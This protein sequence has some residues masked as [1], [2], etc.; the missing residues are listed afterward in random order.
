M[1]VG[2][3]PSLGVTA[4]PVIAKK[5][6]ERHGLPPKPTFSALQVVWWWRIHA[7]APDF[8]SML[9]VALGNECHRRD[10]EHELHGGELDI[11][12]VQAYCAFHTAGGLGGEAY[13]DA[14]ELGYLEK[15][16]L[17]QFSAGLMDSI[18]APIADDAEENY[19]RDMT[20]LRYLVPLSP[21]QVADN[22]RAELAYWAS[23][24]EAKSDQMERAKADS[25]ASTDEIKVDQ[26]GSDEGFAR[27]FGLE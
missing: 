5:M 26:E 10:I 6:V 24:E 12:D 20:R 9:C 13:R 22:A 17:R 27:D 16:Q 2:F 1:R 4:P 3:D 18:S 23:V 19:R 8:T 21:D 14:V 15:L 25:L 11:S 7:L